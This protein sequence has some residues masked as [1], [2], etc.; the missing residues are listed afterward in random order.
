MH[1]HL[2][3]SLEYI[4]LGPREQQKN[5]DHLHIAPP[6][7]EVDILLLVVLQEGVQHLLEFQQ[8]LESRALQ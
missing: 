5:G 2:L 7:S 1:F 8:F 3:T 6:E 4:R